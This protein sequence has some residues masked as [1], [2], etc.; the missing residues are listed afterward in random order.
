MNK[1]CLVI[2]RGNS[3]SGKSYLARKLQMYY[4]TENCFL[5]QQDV[6]RRD[7]LHT[8][9]HAGNLA[10]KLIGKMI[11]FGLEYYPVT[12]VE[13]ILRKDV[14][15]NML[16][17]AVIKNKGTSLIFYLDLSFEKTLLLNLHKANPFSEKILRQWWQEKDYLGRSDICLRD[18]DFLTNFNQVLEKIDSQLS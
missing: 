4:G 11:E 5:I 18:A 3:G 8:H 9:D 10:I 7:I 6:V 15:S 16:H 17:N 1:Q 14:Y 13:G 2:I 12:I